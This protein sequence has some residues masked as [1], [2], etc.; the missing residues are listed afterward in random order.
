MSFRLRSKVGSWGAVDS[1][2]S[3]AELEGKPCQTT[4][5]IKKTNQKTRAKAIKLV[6]ATRSRHKTAALPGKKVVR[7][8]GLRTR[9]TGTM[10]SRAH[11]PAAKFSSAN[12]RSVDPAILA[13]ANKKP[14]RK[15]ANG[16]LACGDLCGTTKPPCRLNLLRCRRFRAT[17]PELKAS[18]DTAC[19]R[20][21]SLV[22]IDVTPTTFTSKSAARVPPLLA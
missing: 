19:H 9:T 7:A 11:R 16:A 8:V 17:L 2:A 10:H 12:R 13:V 5:R 3:S 18:A 22:C 14:R 4:N 6:R 1:L 15:R 21:K 20:I